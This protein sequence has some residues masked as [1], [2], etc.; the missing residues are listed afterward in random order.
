V[1]FHAHVDTQKDLNN[2]HR[3]GCITR[4]REISE[5]VSDNTAHRTH[6][7]Q[8]ADHDHLDNDA[9]PDHPRYRSTDDHYDSAGSE[10]DGSDTTPTGALF[11]RIRLRS[12]NRH[13]RLGDARRPA[14]SPS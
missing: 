10:D 13:R 11:A 2:H 9:A 14:L 7:D 1:Q 5:P 3:I 12:R 4:R 6:D 8:R